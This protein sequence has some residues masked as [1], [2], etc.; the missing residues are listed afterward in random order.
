MKRKHIY[1]LGILI[2]LTI[3]TALFSNNF[4]A[5]KYI[6]S[7]ILA[8]SCVKFLLVAFQFMELKKAHIFWKIL[9]ISYVVIFNTI[10]LIVYS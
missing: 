10:L 6:V 4:S 7:I 2:A 5:F 3:L 8:L 1:I 9:L